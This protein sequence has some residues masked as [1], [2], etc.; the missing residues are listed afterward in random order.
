MTSEKRD[1]T[2]TKAWA[3]RRKANEAGARVSKL[4][5]QLEQAQADY[6]SCHAELVAYQAT[7]GQ[8]P[9]GTPFEAPE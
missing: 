1:W 7:R 9:D 4:V 2:E 5:L 6:R 3:L 8:K